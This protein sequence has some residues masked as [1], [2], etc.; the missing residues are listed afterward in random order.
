MTDEEREFLAAQLTAL[1][2]TVASLETAAKAGF[3]VGSI[4]DGVQRL[5]GI[6]RKL[7][8][9]VATPQ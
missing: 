2:Q 7:R 8:P 9:L 5:R 1:D 4:E 6:Y 3:P